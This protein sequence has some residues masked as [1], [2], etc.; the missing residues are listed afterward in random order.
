MELWDEDGRLRHDF[1]NSASSSEVSAALDELR[2]NASQEDCEL[3]FPPDRR[4]P[5]GDACPQMSDACAPYRGVRNGYLCSFKFVLGPHQRRADDLRKDRLYV[6]LEVVFQPLAER[7]RQHRMP[8]FV[9]YFRSRR[10][11]SLGYYEAVEKDGSRWSF[12]PCDD[13]GEARD[14]ALQNMAPLLSSAPSSSR[15]PS[16]R[17][18]SPH[19][20]VVD[21]PQPLGS[22]RPAMTLSKKRI[23]DG[24]SYESQLER[25][26]HCAMLRMGIEYAPNPGA[27]FIGDETRVEL[28]WDHYTPDASAT[29][30]VDIP[31]I[32]KHEMMQVLVE[33]KPTPPTVKECSKLYALAK[34]QD[35]KVLCIYGDCKWVSH[36]HATMEVISGYERP[37][38]HPFQAKLYVP[39]PNKEDPELFGGL[40]WRCDERGYYLGTEPSCPNPAETTSIRRVYEKAYKQG[41][42]DWAAAARKTVFVAEEAPAEE[43]PAEEA[44][45]EEAPAEEAPADA[46]RLDQ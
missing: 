43:A 27:F 14:R 7:N 6:S 12:V 29:L 38:H 42:K 28:K 18:R 40:Q 9:A 45:A 11:I 31:H 19:R 36:P 33:I 41:S 44:P 35:K 26:H 23:I 13:Q 21:V 32:A 20:H 10:C 8:I 4:R 16:D 34:Q 3:F 24:F 2:V 46:M 37:L 1:F 17:S 39:H 30:R 15:P 25:V 22:C 5:L